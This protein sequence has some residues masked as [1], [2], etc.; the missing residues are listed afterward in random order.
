MLDTTDD[1]VL[2]E[3]AVRG[4]REAF[5]QLLERHYDTI[6]RVAY[7][8]LGSAADAEDVAQDVCLTLVAKLGRFGNR[9]RFS[10]W[11]I[12]VVINRCRDVLRRRKASNA[13]AERYV[14][15]RAAE[16]ADAADSAARNAWL[17]EALQSLEPAL[18]ETVVLVVAEGMSHAE[19]A[20][21]L[22]CAENT[23]S[24]RMHVARRRLKALMDTTDG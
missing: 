20:A 19:A 21:S 10:T 12:S 15:F 9:S 5:R 2:A 16:E 24:W 14:A 3:A 22:G 4:D 8:Y 7:R 23:V 1:G 6:Y 17:G 11:L 13:L 18:R